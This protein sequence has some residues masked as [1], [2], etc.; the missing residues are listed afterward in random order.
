M[1]FRG[2]EKEIGAGPAWRVQKMRTRG[3]ELIGGGSPA[4]PF[5]AQR[6]NVTALFI[7]WRYTLGMI[8]L[9]CLAGESLDWSCFVRKTEFDLFTL[10][11]RGG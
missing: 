10:R 11:Y 8:V 4:D 7:E 9:I 6:R 5:P 1:C 3:E 2:V